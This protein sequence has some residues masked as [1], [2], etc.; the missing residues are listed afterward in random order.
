MRTALDISMDRRG[1]IV[2]VTSHAYLG[3]LFTG[4]IFSTIDQ[5]IGLTEQGGMQH[6]VDYRGFTHILSFN[7]HVAP[8]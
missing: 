7:N 5:G 2:Y 1:W 6:E 4:P 8:I 3:V